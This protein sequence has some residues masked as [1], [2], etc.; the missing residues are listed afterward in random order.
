M[1]RKPKYSPEEVAAALARECTDCHAPTGEMCVTWGWGLWEMGCDWVTR[2][3][4]P[5][6]LRVPSKEPT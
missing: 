3:K 2:R 4:E 1:T 6:I 5:H